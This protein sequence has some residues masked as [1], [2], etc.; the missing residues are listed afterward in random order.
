MAFSVSHLDQSSDG[1]CFFGG[2][3]LYLDMDTS[4]G[5][6]FRASCSSRYA[7]NIP[8]SP[9]TIVRRPTEGIANSALS[10]THEGNSAP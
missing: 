9:R 8:F 1:D 6:Y 2:H 7:I 4:G 5:Y 3:L 10:G